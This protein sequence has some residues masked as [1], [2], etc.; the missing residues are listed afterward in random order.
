MNTELSLGIRVTH[1]SDKRHGLVVGPAQHGIGV[2]L[3]PIAVEGS[4]RNELWPS[5][6]CTK[7]VKRH[8]LKAHGGN[9]IPP[10]GYPLTPGS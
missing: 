4:T 6:L 8:Q 1:K 5:H 10:K 9:F 7:K 3:I 2:D